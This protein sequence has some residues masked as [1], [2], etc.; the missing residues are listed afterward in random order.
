MTNAALMTN[1]HSCGPVA[2]PALRPGRAHL[3]TGPAYWLYAPD[4][5]IAEGHIPGAEHQPMR[6]SVVHFRCPV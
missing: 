6:S 5:S 2:N 4:R 1:R 3:P